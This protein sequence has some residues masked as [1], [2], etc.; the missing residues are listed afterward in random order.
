MQKAT[1]EPRVASTT[2]SAD[3]P[4]IHIIVVVVS[5]TTLPAPPALL[6]ATSAARNPMWTLPLKT[7]RAIVPPI[8]AAAMLSRNAD[9]TKTMA[10]ST[11]PPVQWVGRILGSLSGILLSSKCFAKIANPRR[12]PRRLTR[13]FHSWP[14]WRIQWN[15]T[16]SL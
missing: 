2:S 3:T 16:P 12:S 7:L 10:R 11:S 9:I 1:A 8:I 15:P 4:S 14:R 6:A 5:P 13:I